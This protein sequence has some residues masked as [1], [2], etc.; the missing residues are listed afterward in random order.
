MLHIGHVGQTITIKSFSLYF[1]NF[2]PLW[3]GRDVT[4]Y[5]IL[6]GLK[7]ARC[8]QVAGNNARDYKKGAVEVR[9]RIKRRINTS[10]VLGHD[11]SQS[12][13][14]L[15]EWPSNPLHASAECKLQVQIFSTFSKKFQ[16][17]NFHCHI[18]IQDEKYIQMTSN[19]PSAGS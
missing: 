10:R 18:L 17:S 13:I 7:Y 16:I 14:S 19:K 12:G 8:C 4:V 5:S 6:A 9:V 15:V 2:I 1:L 3:D 11:H